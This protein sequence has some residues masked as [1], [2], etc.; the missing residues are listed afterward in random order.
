[1]TNYREEQT[2]VLRTIEDSTDRAAIAGIRRDPP[3]WGWSNILAGL[4]GFWVGRTGKCFSVE[5]WTERRGGAS[6]PLRLLRDI[7]P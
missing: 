6:A 2:Q 5:F 4:Y 7:R 1:L 3:S